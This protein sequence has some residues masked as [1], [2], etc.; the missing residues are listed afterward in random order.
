VA[1]G[2]VADP[3]GPSEPLSD[4]VVDRYRRGFDLAVIWL[5]VAWHLGNDLV[6]M[7]TSPGVYRSYPAEVAGWTLMTATGAAGAVRLLRGRPDRVGSWLLAVATLAASGLATAQVPAGQVFAAAHWA[8]DSTGWF[9]VLLLLRRPLLELV[10]FTAVNSGLTLAV[11]LS[12][13]GSAGLGADRLDLARFSTAAY[14]T[15]ALQL[16]LAI[17]ARA[18]DAAA[19]RAVDAAVAEAAARRH[20]QVAEEL[21]ARR[22][23]RYQ[24]VRR[25]VAPL[26]AG[27]ASGE[28]DPTDRA[29]RHRCAVAASRLRRLFAETD[30]A[31]DPLLHELRACADIADRRGVLV[32]LQVLGRLPALAR[33]V[34]RALTEAPLHALAGAER[35]ARVTVVGRVDEVAVSVLADGTGEGLVT[36]A[37]AATDVTVTVQTVREGDDRRWTE[38]RWRRR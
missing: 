27:L 5:V 24:E 1:D 14:A 16:T 13:P 38:A 9:G 35:Q 17:A 23:E 28:L 15:A 18:V 25:S 32:D 12:G 10:A 7:V 29:V 20:G 37:A 6:T 36:A 2:G 4:I 34:R 33:P 3:A 8:W 21:H 26:L 30:D 19:R 11:L 31:P 22:Q